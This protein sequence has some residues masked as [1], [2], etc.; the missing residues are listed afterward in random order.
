MYIIRLPVRRDCRFADKCLLLWRWLRRGRYEPPD[1]PPQ[2]ALWGKGDGVPN[3]T[4]RAFQLS[5]LTCPSTLLPRRLLL[6]ITCGFWGRPCLHSVAI[7]Y[8]NYWSSIIH[9]LFGIVL[10]SHLGHASGIGAYLILLIEE[11]NPLWCQIW[12]CLWHGNRG[13]TVDEKKLA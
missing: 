3:Q 5:W 8:S 12:L 1:A 2:V 13:V 11:D 7:I 10:Y 6:E 9:M 4:T